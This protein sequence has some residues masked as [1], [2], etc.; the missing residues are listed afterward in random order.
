MRL[1]SVL[2][3]NAGGNDSNIQWAGNNW[4]K[5]CDFPGNDMSN[6]QI[7][8]ED[9]GGKCAQTPNCTHF[10]WTRYLGGTCWLKSG[11]VSKKDAI[12]TSD[13]SMV[14]GLMEIY[15][16]VLWNGNNWA[17]SCD[18]PGND[19][20]N[21][22]I[23]GEDCGGLCANTSNCTHFTWTTYLNGTCWLKSG[24]VSK[25]DAILTTDLTMV[26]GVV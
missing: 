14:C 17:L 4:A 12:E 8:G 7:S 13:P 20:S 9:C 18:F 1:F 26:C 15:S 23:S 11:E 16:S 25:N 3:G 19:M 24:P 21:V 6:V 5:S 2:Y 10:T 22:Q